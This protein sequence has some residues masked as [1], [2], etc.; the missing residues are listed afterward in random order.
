M[1]FLKYIS[2]NRKK[3]AHFISFLFIFFS[4]FTFYKVNFTLLNPLTISIYYV[5]IDCSAYSKGT[6][7]I[8]IVPFTINFWPATNIDKTQSTT[9]VKV[10]KIGDFSLVMIQLFKIFPFH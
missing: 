1:I 6:L 8:S 5:T 7:A 2:H 10:K 9:I 4:S 3:K